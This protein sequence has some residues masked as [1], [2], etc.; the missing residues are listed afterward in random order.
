MAAMLLLLRAPV[1]ECGPL[2]DR[3]A[4]LGDQRDTGPVG[5]DTEVSAVDE[6]ALLA[7]FHGEDELAHRSIRDHVEAAPEAAL[8]GVDATNQDDLEWAMQVG[9]QIGQRVGGGAEVDRSFQRLVQQWADRTG[10]PV[11]GPGRTRPCRELNPGADRADESLLQELGMRKGDNR[12]GDVGIA[13]DG[14]EFGA[15]GRVAA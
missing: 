6:Q 2:T 11:D 4:A 7:A 5:G 13:G 1:A 12:F 10:M 9:N 3:L 8:E 14:P 15:Q